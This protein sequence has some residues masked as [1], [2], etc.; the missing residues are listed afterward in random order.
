MW[1]FH[2]NFMKKSIPYFDFPT[3]ST[4]SA[5]IQKNS[6]KRQRGRQLHM[7]KKDYSYRP[8]RLFHRDPTNVQNWCAH[9]SPNFANVH[10]VQGLISSSLSWVAVICASYTAKIWLIPSSFIPPC[11]CGLWQ[12]IKKRPSKNFRFQSPLAR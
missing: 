2:I 11:S 8:V 12:A 3:I 6:F 9:L 7:T 1:H 5:F 10:D 4:T